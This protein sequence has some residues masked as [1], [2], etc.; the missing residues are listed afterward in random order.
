[1]S[2]KYLRP[3]RSAMLPDLSVMVDVYAVLQ[4]FEVHCPAR[5]HAIKKLLAAGQ[6]G[7]KDEV[8]DLREA[9]AAI[10]RSIEMIEP[11]TAATSGKER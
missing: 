9:I 7:A 3:I 6:R 10:E 11:L 4:A 8:T 5:Q 1:M 2:N